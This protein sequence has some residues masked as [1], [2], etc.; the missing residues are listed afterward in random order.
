MRKTPGLT[1]VDTEDEV[2]KLTA[3]WLASPGTIDA[4]NSGFSFRAAYTKPETPVKGS[5]RS[6][7]VRAEN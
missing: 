5:A 2:D 3:Q 4:L 1:V 7:K 6:K